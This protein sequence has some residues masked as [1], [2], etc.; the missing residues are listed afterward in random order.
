MSEP[1]TIRINEVD[2]IRK[3]SIKSTEGDIK[4]VVVDRGFVYVGRLKMESNL[5]VDS[6][7]FAVLTDARNIRVWGTTAG[8]GEL[9]S[10]PTKATK[11][12]FVGTVRIPMRAVISIIDTEQ[13]KWKSVI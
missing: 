7:P 5:H 2:Y 6:I 3:D 4:I 9:I 8:L 11:L 12:D 10:G 1:S 13:G